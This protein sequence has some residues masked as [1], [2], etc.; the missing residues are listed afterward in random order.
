M[1]T[2]PKKGH[3]HHKAPSKIFFRKIRGM[4]P[5]KSERGA[6]A[7]KRIQVYDGIPAKYARVPRAHVPSAVKF[8]RIDLDREHT[9]LG[10]LSTLAGWKYGEV[11]KE[12]EEKRIASSKRHYHEVK[13][14]NNKYK[15]DAVKNVA[16]NEEYKQLTQ[17][18]AKYGF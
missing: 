14:L 16:E 7:L 6:Q 5:Y 18:L 13:A 11:V 1:A 3:F 4:L 15:N 9:V 12:Q 10:H 2:N 8:G 17:E